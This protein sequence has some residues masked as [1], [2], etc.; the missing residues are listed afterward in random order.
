MDRPSVIENEIASVE[1]VP[2]DLA[3][4]NST[5]G[6]IRSGSERATAL[7]FPCKKEAIF[8]LDLRKKFFEENRSAA[9]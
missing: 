4:C 8:C 9:G 5:A 1:L 6:W 3:G 7:C 2:A